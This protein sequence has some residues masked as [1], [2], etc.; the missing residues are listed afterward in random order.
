MAC[1]ENSTDV[2]HYDALTRIQDAD[3]SVNTLE[4]LLGFTLV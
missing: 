3:G 1:S 4:V 2:I